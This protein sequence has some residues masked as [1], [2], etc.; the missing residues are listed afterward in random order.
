MAGFYLEIRHGR[1]VKAERRR[2]EV[3]DGKTTAS[4]RWHEGTQSA[5]KTVARSAKLPRSWSANQ[6]NQC[7]RHFHDLW[8][9]HR[10]RDPNCGHLFRRDCRYAN[11]S[12]AGLVL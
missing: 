4:H 9:E 2:Q 3:D 8:P 1:K 6:S 7:A 10:D 5:Q 11:A 12:R